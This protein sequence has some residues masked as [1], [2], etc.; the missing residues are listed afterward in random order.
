MKK[1]LP[2]LPLLIAAAPQ[3]EDRHGLPDLTVHDFAAKYLMQQAD[4]ADLHIYRDDNAALIASADSRPRIVLLGDSITFHWKP[5][6]RPAPLSLNVIDRGIVGQNSDQMLMRFEDDVVALR[7][8][9]VVL[10]G[11]AND[12]RIYAGAPAEARAAVIQRIARNI[13]AMADIADARRIKVAV[14]AITPCRGCEALNRDPATLVAA[15]DWLHR[16]AAE[17]HYPFIDYYAA[18]T[19]KDAGLTAVLG[20][21]GLHPTPQGYALMWPRLQAAL[22]ALGLGTR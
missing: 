4:I 1:L 11:G 17:R 18:L 9:V 16:F 5:D 22:G 13:T 20:Q 10:A 6:Y 21:D 3:A 2:I 8:A 7:P 15:N 19:G 14:A 12:L